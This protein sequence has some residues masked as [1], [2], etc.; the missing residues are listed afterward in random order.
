MKTPSLATLPSPPLPPAPN[1]VAHYQDWAALRLNLLWIYEGPVPDNGQGKLAETKTEADRIAIMTSPIIALDYCAAWL[2]TRGEARVICNGKAVTAPAGHWLIPWPG[3]REQRFTPGTELLSARFQ[4]HWPDGRALFDEGL[5]LAMPSR[6]VPQ[7]ETAARRLLA[8]VR[9]HRPDA[10][11]RMLGA[12][13]VPLPDFI[14]I[15]IA[16]LQFIRCYTD[17]LVSRGLK[18]T[19]LG[20]CDERVL[21]ALSQLDR[22][23]LHYKFREADFAREIGLGP[24][25]FARLF[26]AQ[27]GMTPKQ[28]I[29]RRRRD[30]CRRMLLHS[31]LPVKQLAAEFGF[32]HHT[33]FSAWFKK[34]NG[35]S[36]TEFRNAYPQGHHV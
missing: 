25:Q 4:A 29:E 8:C 35:L 20:T 15:K 32:S 16:T 17:A 10:N 3:L 13:D 1:L 18:P 22:L 7:L 27:M 24:S 9:P 19:R 34:F 36:P 28:Y 6:D 33:D 21:Q 26:S 14:D 30:S 11:A 12:V 31:S 5:S 2:V 23:P